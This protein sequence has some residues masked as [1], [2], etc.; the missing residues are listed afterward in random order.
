MIVISQDWVLTAD[1]IAEIARA[2]GLEVARAERATCDL[3]NLLIDKGMSPEAPVK[4][5]RLDTMLFP[6]PHS[7]TGIKLKTVA[8]VDFFATD[9]AQ[10]T[11]E[12]VSLYAPE[13][14]YTQGY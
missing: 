3:A 13:R 8:D 6:P 11:E 2:E 4:L 1:G 7:F 10:L 14:A 9:R 5:M 12:M